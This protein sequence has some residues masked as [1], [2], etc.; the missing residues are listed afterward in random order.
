VSTAPVLLVVGDLGDPRCGVGSSE[1]ALVPL[2]HGEVRAI[3]PTA[4]SL[5]DFRRSLRADAAGAAGVVLAYPTNS[6]VE[7]IALVPRLLVVRWTMRRRWVRL[8]LHEFDRL[9]RRLRIPVALMTGIVADR[10]VVSSQREAD[11]LRTSYRGWAARA[12]IVVAPPANGQAPPPGVGTAPRPGVVGVVGQ[13][14]PDK[15]LAWLLDLLGRLDPAFDQLEVVGRGWDAVRWPD[16]V[17]ERFTITLHGE[18]DEDDLT[19]R[20]AGWELAL[21]PYDEPP[22]DGRLSLR[23]PLAHGIPTLTR[24]PRPPDLQLT[25]PHL[26]FD[27]EVDVTALRLPAGEQRPALAAGIAALEQRF[28]VRLVHELFEP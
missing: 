9:R 5:R 18:V 25:A 23:T 13:L 8:H 28:R 20:I 11:A 27:D 15:G 24:G 14:R 7:R 17:A 21:A 2:V 19:D 12:E 16:A 6:Q 22:H 10:V 4:G 3:D 1:A 26:L